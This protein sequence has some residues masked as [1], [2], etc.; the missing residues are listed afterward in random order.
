MKFKLSDKRILVPFLIALL[1]TLVMAISVFMPYATAIGE[2]KEALETATNAIFDSK[3]GI[4][5]ESVKD[6]SLYEFANIYNADSQNIF[7]NGD[8]VVYIVIIAFIGCF[9]LLGTIFAFFKKATPIIVFTMLSFLV[10]VFNN[11]DFS[12]RGVVPSKSYAYGFGYYV[13]YIATVLALAG[14]I[15][16]IIAKHKIKKEVN[17]E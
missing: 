4:S 7:G 10:F 3:L 15:L 9:A 12:L 14:A 17:K 2:Y 13:F 6:V 1:G 8:G 11:Y 16:L 5:V